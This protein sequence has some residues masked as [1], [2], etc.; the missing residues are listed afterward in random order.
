MLSVILFLC[1]LQEAHSITVEL[2]KSDG[3]YLREENTNEQRDPKLQFCHS[4]L[5]IEHDIVD[6]K[7]KKLDTCTFEVTGNDGLPIEVSPTF[8]CKLPIMSFSCSS[9]KYK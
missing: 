3:C 9:T 4:H 5:V 1:Y 7:V 6:L 2:C 8:N